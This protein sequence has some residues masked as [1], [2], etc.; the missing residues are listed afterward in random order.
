M[1]SFRTPAVLALSLLIT[2]SACGTSAK[3]S[4]RAADDPITETTVVATTVV[5]STAVGD[6]VTAP[7]VTTPPATNPPPTTPPA[8]TPE[9][10]KPTFNSFTVS[11]ATPC[12]PEVPNY[13]YPDITVSWDISGATSV[14]VALD[15]EFGP[16]EQNLP[17]AGSLMVPAPGCKDSQTYYVVAE[18]AFGRT[19]EQK[20]YSAT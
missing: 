2:L 6:P 12:F 20:T 10:K 8:T 16:W 4:D 14:Y 1:K 18:N 3:S 13:E 5:A 9:N 11:A 19:V 15:N 7:A 17:A